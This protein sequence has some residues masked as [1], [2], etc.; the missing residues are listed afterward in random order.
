M[1]KLFLQLSR[2][3]LPTSLY[4]SAIGSWNEEG[5]R[6]YVANTGWIFLGKW[7]NLTISLIATLVIARHLGPTNL[8]E[9]SYAMSFIAIFSFIAVFGIDSVL[10]R[11]LIKHPKKRN[12]YL[13]SAL[14]IKLTTAA[15]ASFLT[16]IFAYF[17]SPRD[18][19]FLL[20]IILSLSFFFQSLY[21]ISYE[22]GAEVK[23]KIIS[24]LSIG[25][26]LL[27]NL[28][29]IL[30][31]SI[32]YGV[33][34]L[35]LIVLFEALLYASGYVYF[36]KKTFGPITD[37]KFD[38]VISKSLIH[39]SWPFIFSGAFTVIYSRI[40]QI[41]LKNMIDATSVGF[42]DVAVRL[43]ELW[44]FIPTVIVGSLFPALVNSRMH[45]RSEYLQ[46][47]FK[48]FAVISLVTLTLSLLMSV[49]A[50][51][52]ILTIFGAKF[53]DSIYI[54]QIYVWTLL[55]LGLINFFN[56]LFL[57]E[58]KKIILFLSSLLGALA[59][60]AGNFI[61][62]PLYASAGAAIATLLSSTILLLLL[63]VYFI[64]YNQK[65]TI[66]IRNSTHKP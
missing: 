10:Y 38:T 1:F 19:S 55:P 14:C 11:E 2:L 45:D 47:V 31:V 35:A 26:T 6:K 36:R 5:L 42:Y 63:I 61:L 66:A 62:I 29:K 17:F 18:V 60:V 40:D 9:F 23:G 43:T 57:V 59:N 16:I 21:I 48:L 25:I 49:F 50:K 52:I 22:F 65:L 20:I 33:I 53:F 12:E 51:P 4:A 56:H 54:L 64:R 3:L 37:W 41:M 58:G 27:I 24:L 34:F 30:I 32:G 46:R 28:L 13:G 8:G 7:G 44:Y 39:N 15:L